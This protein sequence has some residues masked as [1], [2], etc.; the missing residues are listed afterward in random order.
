ME[1]LDYVYYPLLTFSFMKNNRYIE[2]KEEATGK[3]SYICERF[4][5]RQL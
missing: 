3:W 5:G 4:V 1:D 2:R